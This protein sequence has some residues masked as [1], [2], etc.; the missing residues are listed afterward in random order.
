MNPGDWIGKCML[1]TTDAWFYA[2][3]GR[4][5]RA[6]W[7]KVEAIHTDDD[8][9]GVRTNA[10]STNWYVKIGGTHIAGCQ[11]HY[12]VECKHPPPAT[13]CDHR[14]TEQGEVKY[15]TRPSDIWRA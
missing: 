8:T 10:R 15:F 4:T 3:D 12:A 2:N 11:V 5:Y 1:I 7:G 13:V 14:V 6:A 9:L